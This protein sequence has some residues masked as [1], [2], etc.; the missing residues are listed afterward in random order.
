MIRRNPVMSVMI[1]FGMGCV[2]ASLFR[3]PHWNDDVSRRMSRGS[4]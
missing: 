1:A 2:V 4:M 3:V